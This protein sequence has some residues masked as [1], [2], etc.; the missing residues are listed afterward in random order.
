MQQRYS[1]FKV[2]SLFLLL[3]AIEIVTMTAFENKDRSV[4]LSPLPGKT[5]YPLL[6]KGLQ[7]QT[8]EADELESTLRAGEVKVAPRNF[9]VFNIKAL[10]ELSFNDVTLEFHKKKGG[11]SGINFKNLKYLP[12]SGSGDDPFASKNFRKGEAKTGSIT[13]GVFNNIALNYRGETG[14]ITRGVIHNIV[15]NLYNET[16]LRFTIKAG[17]AYINFRRNKAKFIDVTIEHMILKKVIKSRV[18]QLRGNDL[19]LK[20]PGKY[21]LI[22]SS[23]VKKGRKLEIM[24]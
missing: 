20:V 21:V 10:N 14:L 13:R 9:L 23:G 11:S 1:Y 5:V 22:S 16:G 12:L 6:I 2:L 17:R 8:Y 3:I 4:S 15:L 24:L 18:V 19:R 7:L